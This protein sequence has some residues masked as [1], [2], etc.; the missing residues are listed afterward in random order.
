[1]SK[2]KRDVEEDIDESSS[3]DESGDEEEGDDDIGTLTG[4][5]KSS[6]KPE[7]GQILSVEAEDF[8][9]HKKFSIKF[10]RNVN[11]VTGANGSGKS[12]IVA[13]IQ[14]CL[15]ASAKTTGWHTICL[16]QLCYFRCLLFIR[17]QR[18]RTVQTAPVGFDSGFILKIVHSTQ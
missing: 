17:S 5:A 4:L 14:L 15:G 3:G 7:T 1:M 8:M 18:F 9:C 10:G 12:A 16:L 11:F 13:A 2:R 6:M